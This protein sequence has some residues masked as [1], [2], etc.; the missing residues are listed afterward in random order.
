[1]KKLL[2][3]ATAVFFLFSVNSCCSDTRLTEDQVKMINAK[4][5]AEVDW[6]GMIEHFKE[7]SCE[8]RIVTEMV[9]FN[10]PDISQYLKQFG[11]NGVEDVRFVFAAYRD[12]DYDR[13]HRDHPDVTREQIINHPT[14][15]IGMKLEGITEVIYLDL[16]T[17]CPPPG[18]CND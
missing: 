14:V 12:A 10:I 11:Q 3:I 2:A 7:L 13:Y 1:M 5:L 16:G 6:K 4:K 15:L 9:K 17:I 8:D 18:S